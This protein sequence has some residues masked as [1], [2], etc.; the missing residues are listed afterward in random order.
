MKNFQKYPETPCIFGFPHYICSLLI[1]AF[2]LIY[3]S[4][5]KKQSNFLWKFILAFQIEDT[6]CFVRSKNQSVWIGSYRFLS[7]KSKSG[8][9]REIK[10]SEN[11]EKCKFFR[12]MPKT[13]WSTLYFPFS[14]S[15]SSRPILFERF[16][17]WIIKIG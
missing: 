4:H 15:T 17:S 7:A 2:H 5:I 8:V 16:G 10:R 14:A 9:K 3:I 12:K 13:S 6:G 1:K 11:P